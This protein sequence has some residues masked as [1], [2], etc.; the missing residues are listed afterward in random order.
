MKYLFYTGDGDSKTYKN[1]VEAR[2]YGGAIKITKKECVGH[3]QKRLR[4]RLRKL[5]KEKKLG[6]KGK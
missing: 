1:I 4:S 3:V 6:G 5:M 2:P